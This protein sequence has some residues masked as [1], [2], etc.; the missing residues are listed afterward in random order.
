[1]SDDEREKTIEMHPTKRIQITRVAM[2]DSDDDDRDAND[3][4]PVFRRG[5]SNSHRERTGTFT[6]DANFNLSNLLRS[7]RHDAHVSWTD[8]PDKNNEEERDELVLYVQR[9]SRMLFAGLVPL[10]VLTDDYLKKLVRVGLFSYRSSSM[11]C[12]ASF[13]GL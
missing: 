2:A 11:L 3:E 10:H 6:N 7:D 5:L 4:L 1:M 8:I 13:S 9:N 12:P